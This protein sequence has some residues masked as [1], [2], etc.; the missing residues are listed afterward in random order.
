MKRFIKQV[1]IAAIYFLVFLGIGLLAWN[2]FY[3]PTCSDGIKNQGEEKIDC[4]GPCPSCEL[5]YAVPPVVVRKVYF[6][7]DSEN[8]IDV[9][10]QLSNPNPN[11]GINNLEYRIDFIDFSNKVIPGSLYGSTFI[12]PGQKKWVVELAKF[13]PDRVKDVELVMSTSTFSWLKLKPYVSEAD[14]VVK[15]VI[16]R[17]LAPFQT[18][19]AEI[20]GTVLNKSG[21]DVENVEVQAVVYDYAKRILGISKTTIFTLKSGELRDFRIFWPR[22]FSGEMKDYELFVNVNMLNNNNFLQKY[23]R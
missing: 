14:F 10:F 7:G 17:K 22:Q 20:V 2:I 15:D 1:I 3:I 12:L 9:G 4:G 16:F 5:K 19:Y 11:W 8:T 6:S 18:G 21:F 23:R 13:V